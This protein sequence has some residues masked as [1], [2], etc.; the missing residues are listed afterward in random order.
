MTKY[1]VKFQ[2][3]ALILYNAGKEKNESNKKKKR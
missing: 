2:F 1:Q 3:P